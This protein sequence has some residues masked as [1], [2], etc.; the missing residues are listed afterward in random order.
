MLAANYCPH[1]WFNHPCPLKSWTFGMGV[2]F[3]TST[4]QL[5]CAGQEE[6]LNVIYFLAYCQGKM[7]Y[8]KKNYYFCCGL[9]VKVLL[10][11]F[12]FSRL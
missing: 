5:A 3:V 10:E 12:F 9:I 6:M 4:H 11:T 2:L 7:K 8:E 1:F